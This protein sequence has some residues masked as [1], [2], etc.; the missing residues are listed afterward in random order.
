M[1]MKLS[2]L[3]RFYVFLLLFQTQLEMLQAQDIARTDKFKKS[4]P[5][6]P[7]NFTKDT[8]IN[9]RDAILG[10]KKMYQVDIL[11]GENLVAGITVNS[12]DGWSK[13]ASA[14]EALAKLLKD[15]KL[16]YK[17]VK[18][19]TYIIVNANA[20]TKQI[21]KQISENRNNAES[22]INSTTNTEQKN[23]DN[24]KNEPT[25]V[26]EVPAIT[27]NGIVLDENNKPLA[28]VTVT[29]KGTQRATATNNDGRFTIDV[30]SE[31][32]ILVFSYVGYEPQE[33]KVGS[34][35]ALKI[36][37]KSKS[38]TL[39][40]VVVVIGYG[41]AKKR[42]LTGSVSQIKSKDIGIFSN[43]ELDLNNFVRLN[44]IYL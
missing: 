5:K 24:S 8:N 41:T 30:D 26:K 40:D 36:N 9:L 23:T 38:G 22:G 27:I 28:G 37:M 3:L 11:F 15:T 32:D 20:S 31:N 29:V 17:K 1:K 42:D 16:K 12:H 2:L 34:N 4:T 18:D 6:G 7:D 19:N 25:P 35:K 13:A 21:K 44:R 10:I 33:V 14:E 43:Q 39:G